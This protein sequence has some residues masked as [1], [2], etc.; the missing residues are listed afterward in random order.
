M[1]SITFHRNFK[2]LVTKPAFIG[3]NV[4]RWANQLKPR[5]G[6]PRPLPVTHPDTSFFLWL[7]LLPPRDNTYQAMSSHR[8]SHRQIS[9]WVDVE[10]AAH[11]TNPF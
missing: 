8:Q 7:M 5:F 2:S 4:P 11:S 3:T 6:N 10:I 9:R 1:S